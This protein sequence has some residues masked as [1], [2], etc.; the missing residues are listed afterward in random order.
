MS[1][2]MSLVT[3]PSDSLESWQAKYRMVTTLTGN[4]FYWVPQKPGAVLDKGWWCNAYRNY[5]A[6]GEPVDYYAGGQTMI[7]GLGLKPKEG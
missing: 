5:F 4:G 7:E 3:R 2:A 6:V 1:T